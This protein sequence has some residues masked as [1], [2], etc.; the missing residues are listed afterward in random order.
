MAWRCQCDLNT[1]K[2]FL[3]LESVPCLKINWPAV[4]L[5]LIVLANAGDARQLK[6]GYKSPVYS[7]LSP[8]FFAT[9][10]FRQAK[11]EIVSASKVAYRFLVGVT[12]NNGL[13]LSPLKTQT[14]VSQD[15]K[16]PAPTE[17]ARAD[18]LSRQNSQQESEPLH[19]NSRHDEALPAS[20]PY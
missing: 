10:L 16:E 18:Q 3:K 4:E 15:F 17:Q 12:S 8:S 20:S 13:V 1:P 9:V 14:E 11:T 2:N 19:Q 5:G 6:F 7:S